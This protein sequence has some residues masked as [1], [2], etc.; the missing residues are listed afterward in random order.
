VPPDPV[1]ERFLLKLKG[2]ANKFGSHYLGF[3][4]PLVDVLV[5][6]FPHFLTPLLLIDMCSSLSLSTIQVLFQNPNSILTCEALLLR[7]TVISIDF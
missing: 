5:Q 7:V 3:K 1:R 4:R 6:C 2:Q